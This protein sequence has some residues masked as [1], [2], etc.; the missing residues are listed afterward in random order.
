M[1]KKR[2]YCDGINRRDFLRVG[3]AG[4][5]G[6]HLSLPALLQRQAMAATVSGATPPA[7]DMSV[8]IVFLMG[9]PS[10]I[11]TF[12][13]KPDAPPDIRGDFR[14]MRTNVPGIQICDLLPRLAGQMDKFSLLRAFTHKDAGHGGADHYMLT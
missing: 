9:G 14:P 6:L 8:I 4:V 5:M 12:D 11:D 10:A 3:A 2:S 13:M 7:N 1:K